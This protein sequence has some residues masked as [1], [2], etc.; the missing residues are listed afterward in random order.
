MGFTLEQL[1][2]HTTNE[3]WEETFLDRTSITDAN[4]PLYK[5]LDLNHFGFYYKPNDTIF[6]SELDSEE[7][8]LEQM[9]H[10]FP[11]GKPMIISYSDSYLLEPLQLLMQVELQPSK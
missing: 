5:I 8:R 3:K 4:Q 2:I 9:M 7:M 1:K 11:Q 10:L 6:I